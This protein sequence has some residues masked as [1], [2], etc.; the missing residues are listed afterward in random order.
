MSH[1]CLMLSLLTNDIDNKHFTFVLYSLDKTSFDLNQ[2]KFH[3]LK[4][5]DGIKFHIIP[6][7]I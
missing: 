5:Y 3:I 4:E 1:Y 7:L 2:Y 6:M